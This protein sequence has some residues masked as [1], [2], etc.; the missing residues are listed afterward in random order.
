MDCVHSSTGEEMNERL[1]ECE[2]FL[3]VLKS[4]HRRRDKRRDDMLAGGWAVVRP[5][6]NVVRAPDVVTRQQR[7]AEARRVLGVNNS[8]ARQQ[9]IAIARS[10]R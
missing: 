4:N 1:V 6:R 2:K 3:K 10:S 5:F 7:R 9:A 8:E